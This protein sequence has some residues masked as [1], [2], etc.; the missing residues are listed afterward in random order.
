MDSW[1]MTIGAAGV[2][3]NT[4]A[5]TGLVIGLVSAAVGCSLPGV[6]SIL[7]AMRSPSPRLAILL[8]APALVVGL[9]LGLLGLVLF[10]SG[11]P[12]PLALGLLG[13]G[14]LAVAESCAYALCAYTIWRQ[15]QRKPPLTKPTDAH[16]S[17]DGRRQEQ[18][19]KSRDGEPRR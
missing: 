3:G 15:R 6:A 16:V 2:A 1:V 17:V 18:G 10:S 11:T 14:G 13:G 5:T 4:D 9:A 7:V 19:G 8:Q 12:S